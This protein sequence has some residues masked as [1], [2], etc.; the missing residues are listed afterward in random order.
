MLKKLLYDGILTKNAY[1]EQPDGNQFEKDFNS[2]AFAFLKDRASLLINYL[3]GFEIVKRSPDGTRGIGI[4][5]FKVGKTLYYIPVFFLNG[6]IK[7]MESII[8]TKKN[9]FYP[10]TEDWID[11]IIG[12][13]PISIGESASDEELSGVSNPNVTE[14]L[15]PP[16]SKVSNDCSFVQDMRKIAD[17]VL[18]CLDNNDKF[19]EILAGII[20]VKTAG[21]LPIQSRTDSTIVNYI[22]Q[23]NDPRLATALLSWVA[24][25][26]AFL[27][28]AAEFYTLPNDFNIAIKPKLRKQAVELKII[29]D[30]KCC[31]QPLNA[32]QQE[33]VNTFNFSITVIR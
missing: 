8:D 14:T 30:N 18:D 20:T 17:D 21:D 28:S 27:K 10:L 2:I 3:L 19:K 13:Q 6:Q 32:K 1:V 23:A 24:E 11:T 25:D 22:K 4:F 12:R 16:M 26:E 9:Q 31:P 33:E 15:L 7:G 29:E 5:G